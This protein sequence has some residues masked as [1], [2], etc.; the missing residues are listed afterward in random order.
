MNKTLMTGLTVLVAVVV[1][2]GGYLLLNKNKTT[3]SGST[4]MEM[5]PSAQNPTTS[6]SAKENT[7]ENNQV[8]ITNFAYAP[9]TITIKA[10]ESI[11]WTNS[12]GVDHSA[13]ADDSSWDTGILSQGESKSIT[14]AK[15][16][17]YKYHCSLHPNM[18]G[19]VIVQ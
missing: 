11:N 3:P 6:E 4:Q 16:G 18:H 1:L 5:T 8:D 17:T 15:T 19:T 2:G 12:D 9:S 10:G 7:E 13:T 14:F